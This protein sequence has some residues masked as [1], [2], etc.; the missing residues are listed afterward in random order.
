MNLDAPDCIFYKLNSIFIIYKKN[1]RNVEML[2]SSFVRYDNCSIYVNSKIVQ[3]CVYMN[4]VSMII[5]CKE[6]DIRCNN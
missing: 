6:I 5:K 2:L 4:E 1:I 3:V